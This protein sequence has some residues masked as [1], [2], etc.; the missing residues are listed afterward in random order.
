MDYL[1]TITGDAIGA[2][3]I[4]YDTASS[5]TQL[6][7]TVSR[8]DM[9]NGR[10]VTGVPTTASAIIVYNA[11]A[12]CQNYVTYFLSTPT[13][14]PT[15]TPTP[16]PTPTPTILDCTIATGSISI[17]TPT[18]TPTP[19]VTPTPTPTFTLTNTPTPTP[20]NALVMLRA[21]VVEF[22]VSSLST[23]Q[24]TNNTAGGTTDTISGGTSIPAYGKN[25]AFVTASPSNVIYRVQK[26]A[27]GNTAIDSG[28]VI[29]YVNG[30]IQASENFNQGNVIDFYLT[31]TVST[32]DSVIIEIQEG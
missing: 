26:T 14:T 16:T 17:P 18:P 27:A 31:V 3:D 15:V 25:D 21:Q 11:D 8:Q 22:S 4:Y 23:F 19:T 10:Y 1:V 12:D 9:L 20:T 30:S 2:F 24:I 6:A 7:A 29:V 32:A 13:P 28:Y 5:G